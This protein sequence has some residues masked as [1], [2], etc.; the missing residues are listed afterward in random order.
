M[1]ATPLTQRIVLTGGRSRLASVVREH[2]SA[3]GASVVSLSRSEGDSHL[4]LENLFV[5]NLLDQSDT[6]LHLAWS[7]VPLSSERNVGL[8]WEQDLPLLHKILKAICAS[9]NRSR[10]HFVFF[11]SGGTV[12]GNARDG[13]P[14]SETDLCAPVGWYG[15]AK[16]AAERVIEE[17]GRRHGLVYTIL[18]ISNPY[19]FPVP[20]H[21]PQGIIPFILK[22]AREGTPLSVWGDGSA[23]KDYLHHRDFT[24][25]LE[26]VIRRRPTGTFNVSHGE[27]HTVHE[28]IQL[29]ESALGKKITTQHTAAHAWDVHDSILDNSRL[30]AATGWQ[31]GVTLAD[32]I[33]RAVAVVTST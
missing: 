13:R 16:V 33:R 2:L 5:G 26:G 17:Y 10:L 15:H 14:S 21:K 32:G 12:Y 31:P 4:G 8:E 22:H 24:A 6:L 3:R 28:V 19:G 7:T 18:R 11:S 23:R 27:S 29:A 25:A 1:D 9:P 30:R 20:A